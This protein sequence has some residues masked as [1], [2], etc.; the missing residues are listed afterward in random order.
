M[1]RRTLPLLRSKCQHLLSSSR[2]EPD[3]TLFYSGRKEKQ[4]GNGKSLLAPTCL[5]SFGLFAAAAA[6]KEGTKDTTEASKTWKSQYIGKVTVNQI[7][8]KKINIWLIDNFCT[9]LCCPLELCYSKCR[10]STDRI[11]QRSNV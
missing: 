2:P 7:L 5:L 11:K 4:T 6:T 3:I 10:F 9:F 1:F 8:T